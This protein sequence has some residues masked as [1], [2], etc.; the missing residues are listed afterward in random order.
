[1]LKP[2][3]PV[4]TP[5]VHSSAAH[6]IMM[7]NS[8]FLLGLASASGLSLPQHTL[9]HKCSTRCDSSLPS[10]SEDSFPEQY[11]FPQVMFRYLS[12]HGA[13]AADSAFADDV[14]FRENSMARGLSKSGNFEGLELQLA[15]VAK[16]LAANES[17]AQE[18]QA[19][20]YSCICHISLH[21][22]LIGR[23]VLDALVVSI[24]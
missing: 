1:M 18:E 22:P 10:V 11:P 19:G 3:S 23:T 16:Q 6:V 24:C 13:T 12:Q 2:V 20:V 9:H 5:T 17:T 7:D 8:M 4:L 14:I 15:E 21:S